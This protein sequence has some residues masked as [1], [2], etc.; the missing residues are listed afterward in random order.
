MEEGEETALDVSGDGVVVSLE[1][2]W[3]DGVCGCLDV[4][5]VLHLGC[6]VVGESELLF[7]SLCEV[8]WGGEGTRLN[9][10]CV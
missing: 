9:F 3:E 10:P 1:N 2:G 4:V 6:G 7:V 5:D 8:D